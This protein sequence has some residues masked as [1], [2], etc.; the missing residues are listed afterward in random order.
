[1]YGTCNTMSSTKSHL[2]DK[3]GKLRNILL[4]DNEEEN[5]VVKK[6]RNPSYAFYYDYD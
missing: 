2:K 5:N 3:T 4:K 1:M 6:V